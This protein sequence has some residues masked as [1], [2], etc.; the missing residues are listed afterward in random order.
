[1]EIVQQQPQQRLAS[2]SK[3]LYQQVQTNVVMEH[4]T[5]IT[6]LDQTEQ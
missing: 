3:Q 4:Q 2:Q 6:A 1:M 5:T